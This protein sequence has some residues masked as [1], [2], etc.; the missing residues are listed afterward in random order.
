VPLPSSILPPNPRKNPSANFAPIQSK[1]PYLQ[2]AELSD[3]CFSARLRRAVVHAL[4]QGDPVDFKAAR[5]RLVHG[6]GHVPPKRFLR[7]VRYVISANFVG[8]NSRT[9][10]AVAS[11]ALRFEFY[12]TIDSRWTSLG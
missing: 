7:T 3:F 10:G 4:A 2:A 5:A 12:V 11:M 1:S 6:S 9:H 8:K